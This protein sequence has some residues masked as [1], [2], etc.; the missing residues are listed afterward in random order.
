MVPRILL[1]IQ[2]TADQN[3]NDTWYDMSLLM[4]RATD[5]S[6]CNI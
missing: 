3:D 1:I 2:S 4:Y 6:G 5:L